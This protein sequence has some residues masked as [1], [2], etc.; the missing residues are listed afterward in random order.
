[1]TIQLDATAWKETD[2]KYVPLGVNS[3]EGIF[4]I[5]RH[6][7]DRNKDTLRWCFAKPGQPR[8]TS[9]D[10]EKELDI[11]KVELQRFI[12]DEDE[13]VA[14]LRKAGVDIY[15]DAEGG[16]VSEIVLRDSFDS[17]EATKAIKGLRKL[18]SVVS[19]VASEELIDSLAGHP[20][21]RSLRFRCAVL[22]DQLDRLAPQLPNL[23]TLGFC[24]NEFT[25]AHAKAIQKCKLLN[26]LRIGRVENN[27]SGLK[28]LKDSKIRSLN[29][30]DCDLDRACFDHIGNH[31]KSLNSLGVTDCRIVEGALEPIAKMERLSNL[32]LKG[33]SI[34]DDQ[35][36]SIK[37][38]TH[39][40]IVEISGTA[41]TNASLAH[42]LQKFPKVFSVRAEDVAFDTGIFQIVS[43]AAP[44]RQFR[45]TVSK[46][47]VSR[48]EVENAGTDIARRI[49]VVGGW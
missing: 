26:W 40:R 47:S 44:D 3:M 24:C 12:V 39:L 41:V 33:K 42:V 25:E 4:E 20:T 16:W 28:Y 29:V 10:V 9:F 7:T 30:F 35:V 46:S 34:T 38:N 1:M 19:Y 49:N 11:T 43:S 31:L 14:R 2:G 23:Q 22:P 21:L 27:L 13:I 6:E 5:H 32:T 45:V 17:I 37:S 36:F 8:P 48:E 15:M 18:S